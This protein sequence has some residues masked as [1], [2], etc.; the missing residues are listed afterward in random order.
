VGN[1]LK[2]CSK[3]K[4]WSFEKEVRLIKLW[5]DPVESKMRAVELPWGYIKEVTLGMVMNE[6]SK[7]KIIEICNENHITVYQSIRSRKT[8]SLE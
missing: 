6:K 7:K 1:F 4:D 5:D 8:F 2:T 3:A